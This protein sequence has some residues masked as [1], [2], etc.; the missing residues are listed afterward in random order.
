MYRWI[1][2]CFQVTYPTSLSCDEF[3]RTCFSFYI[4]KKKVVFYNDDFTTTDYGVDSLVSIFKKTKEDAQNIMQTV[5]N[6]GY[7]VVG[8]YTYDIAVTR[9]EVTKSIAKQNG[10]PLRVEI[11]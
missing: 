8:C 6:E 4:E 2:Q 11:E 9:V 10:F 3:Q 5:H 7:S 1:K